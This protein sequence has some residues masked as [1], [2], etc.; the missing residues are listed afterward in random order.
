MTNKSANFD[1]YCPTCDLD[2]SELEKYKENIKSEIDDK[3]LAH[4]IVKTLGLNDGIFT[5]PTLTRNPKYKSIDKTHNL[6]FKNS[7]GYDRA[8]LTLMLLPFIFIL[9]VNYDDIVNLNLD[10]RV[11]IVFGV[12]LITI[13]IYIYRAFFM[14]HKVKIRITKTGIEYYRNQ[15]SW[16]TIID[17]GILKAKSAKANEHKIIVGTI[18]KGIIEMN[19]TSL[20]V[21]PEEFSDI[22]ILNTK[23]VLQQHI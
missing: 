8:A 9:V 12:L 4:G 14:K 21:S 2:A 18:T 16:N 15:I 23:N 3:Y 20:N 7:V 17:I 19:L 22:V 11:L 5:R 13:P 10:N 1:N 6:T